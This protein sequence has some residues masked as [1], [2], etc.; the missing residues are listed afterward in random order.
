[1]NLCVSIFMSP[2]LVSPTRR[3]GLI[4]NSS[5]YDEELVITHYRDAPLYPTSYDRTLYRTH[6]FQLA[7]VFSLLEYYTSGLDTRRTCVRTLVR[8]RKYRAY[9]LHFSFLYFF[10]SIT[11]DPIRRTHRDCSPISLFVRT[12]SHIFD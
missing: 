3:R 9:K 4:I 6:R 2:M 1:M 7:H 12:N 10:R 8:S 11:Y 5:N